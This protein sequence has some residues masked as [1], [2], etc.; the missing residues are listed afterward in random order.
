MSERTQLLMQK[1]EVATAAEETA[2]IAEEGLSVAQKHLL[3][4]VEMI[5][6]EGARLIAAERRHIE[7]Q[8]ADKASAKNAE[9]RREWAQQKEQTERKEEHT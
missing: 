8:R 3:E 6:A 5:R 9:I 2:K 7:Q 1:S 4:T